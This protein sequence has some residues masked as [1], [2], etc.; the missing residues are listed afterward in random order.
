M[1]DDYSGVALDGVEIFFLE[2]VTRFRGNE[3]LPGE[4]NSAAGVFRSDRFLGSQRFI[5]ADDEFGNV[6]E[7]GELR[8]VDDQAEELA[9]VDVTVLAFVFATFHVEKS[10]VE[11]EKREA[12]RE[13]LFA[14][15]RIVVRGV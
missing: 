1:V 4:G 15:R 14:G 6:V 3:H 11:P 12:E 7:P 9:G 13:K 5:N 10:L 2:G 8:V